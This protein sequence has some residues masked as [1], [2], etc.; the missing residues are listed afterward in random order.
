MPGKFETSSS[1]A[2]SLRDLFVYN[3]PLDNYRSLPAKINSVSNA[4]V[5]KV[6]EKYLVPTNMAVI[7]VGD[8]AKIEPELRKLNLGKIEELDYE[9][10]IVK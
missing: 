4:D 10:N 5:S 7:T 2:G 8:E 9:G 3:L 1:S 6:V